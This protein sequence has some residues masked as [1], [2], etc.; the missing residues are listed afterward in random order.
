M[1]KFEVCVTMKLVLNSAICAQLSLLSITASAQTAFWQEIGQP[2]LGRILSL[3]V[4]SN[5]HIFAAADSA[6]WRSTDGGS[7]LDDLAHIQY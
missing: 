3:A 2:T 7:Y 6:L 1:S 5:N 4:N